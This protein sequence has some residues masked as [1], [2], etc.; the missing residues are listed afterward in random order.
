MIDFTIKHVKIREEERRKTW[1]ISDLMN[2]SLISGVEHQVFLPFWQTAKKLCRA[3]SC[4]LIVIVL[5]KQMNEDAP[6]VLMSMLP[7]SLRHK[8]FSPRPTGVT[9]PKNE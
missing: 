2:T 1:K 7:L 5:R 6:E 9:R 8:W 4:S 3:C